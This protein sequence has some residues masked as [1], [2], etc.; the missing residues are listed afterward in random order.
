[1]QHMKILEEVVHISLR[2]VQ[3][4]LDSLNIVSGSCLKE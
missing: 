2:V 4:L 3:K 1:M